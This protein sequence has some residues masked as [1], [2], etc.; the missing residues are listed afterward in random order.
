MSDL[1]NYWST[2]ITRRRTLATVGAG[3][4]GAAF[5]AAC[6]G[7]DSGSGTK[8][9]ETRKAPGLLFEPVDT[10]KQATKGGTW[11]AFV[12]SE[13]QGFDPYRGDNIT[14]QHTEHVYQRLVSYKQGSAGGESA[15]GS[16]VG[17]AAESYEIS[18]DKLTLTFKVRPNQKWDP[19]PPTN[20]RPLTSADVKFSFD[21]ISQTSV[22]NGRELI[23][24]FNPQA[25]ILSMTFPDDRTA[26]IKLKE[27][28]S[29][30]L[31]ILGYSWYFSVIPSESADKFD[32]R[33]E[34]RGSGP[35]MLNKWEKNVGY[36]YL[37]NP[38]YWKTDRPFLDGINYAVITE[39][40]QQL[41]QFKAKRVAAGG[42]LSI[43][44]GYAPAADQV[45]TVLRENPGVLLRGI[46]AFVGQSSK[47]DLV[48]SKLETPGNPFQDARIRHAMSMLIDRD[49]MLDAFGNVSN[50]AR[51]GIE[52]E[53]G[54]HSHFGCSWGASG[55]WLDPKA[56]K[57]GDASK[58]WKFNPQE[59]AN[60]MK[61]AGKYPIETEYTFSGTLPFGTPAYKQANQVLIE[62][63]QQG[64]HFKISKIS[65]PDHFAVYDPKY[66]FG[67]GQY[68]GISPE[69]FGTWPD[70]DMGIWA[71]YMPGGRNDYVYKAV[72]KADGLAKQHRQEFDRKKRLD[73]VHEWQKAMAVEMPTIPVPWTG[74]QGGFSTFAFHWPWLANL[75]GVV[76]PITNGQ[77]ADTFQHYWYD[78]SKDNRTN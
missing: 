54:W 20:S 35:W 68:E 48:P 44:N 51:E 46:S 69:P 23:N 47:N 16:V 56:G 61:A 12:G 22:G 71:I 37:R 5:L 28:V 78:K 33:N 52:V 10:S 45:L 62:Q 36:E 26:V 63:L 34:Q 59:A 2:R 13:P 19:R 8:Q 60:L 49:A 31:A 29:A 73:I 27:P 38:N 11:Q 42:F 21:K 40:A 55:V 77:G 17:D 57:L 32:M 15:D 18:P 72:P 66:L 41:A 24:S 3:A 43:G 39:P 67:H 64:G 65:T 4:L 76:P 70:A 74:G 1:D 75:G 50:L 25:P 9:G 53:T 6:G 58:Y 14:F 30:I 7:S